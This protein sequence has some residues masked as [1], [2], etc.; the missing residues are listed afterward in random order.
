ML[1]FLS[2]KTPHCYRSWGPREARLRG[3]LGRSKQAVVSFA[4]CKTE[5]S[6]LCSDAGAGDGNRSAPF[7]RYHAA[8]PA[9]I[10]PRRRQARVRFLRS[11]PKKHPPAAPEGVFLERVMG[12]EP[13]WPAWE[14]GA[15]PLSY[16]RAKSIITQPLLFAYI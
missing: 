3:N 15:L 2:K 6:E 12:I 5:Q 1:S 16:T 7:G 8:S 11:F 4:A 10:R 13:T 9:F 14:A